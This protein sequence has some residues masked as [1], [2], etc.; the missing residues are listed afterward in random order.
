MRKLNLFILG[1]FF[2]SVCFSFSTSPQTG[3][4]VNLSNSKLIRAGSSTIEN[5]MGDSK[6]EIIVGDSGGM[7]YAVNSTGSE[8]WRYNTGT[9]SIES[10]PAVADL[11]GNGTKEIIVSSGSTFTA[12]AVGSLTVLNNNGTF[13]CNYTPQPFSPQGALGVFSSPAVANLDSDP[14]LEIVI[15]DWGANILVLNHDCSILW[16]SQ[17]APAVTGVQL[18]PGFNEQVAPHK[19]YVND[20]IWSSPAIADMNKDG[21]LDIIIGVDSHIDDNNI[22]ID[23]GRILV[24]NG[25]N[26]TVQ[27]AID[28]DEVIWSSPAIADINNDGNL[29]IIV[30]TGYCW[31]NP[32]CVPANISH[33]VDNKIY[34]YNLNGTPIAGWPFDLGDFATVTSSPAIADI[35]G[36]GS[37][38][39]IVHAFLIG[40]GPPEVG[41]VIVLNSNGTPKWQRR[42]NVP[43]F[44]DPNGCTFIEYAAKNASPIV[45]D[46]TGDGELDVILP[47]NFDIV[48]WDKNG[49]QLLPLPPPGVRM[50][51]SF[52]ISSTPNIAD[53]DQDGDYELIATGSN[54]FT[55]PALPASIYVWD[56]DAA[57]S[58]FLPWRSFRNG[59]KNN[60]LF[61]ADEIFE[62]GFE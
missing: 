44:C 15:G 59:P 18:P 21:Q 6:P 22:T 40:S 43:N 46:M 23:G 33:A 27:T 49:T 57:T 13:K 36:D 26:G 51:T 52:T 12:A 45:V 50:L 20:T 10:K 61:L 58:T 14:E 41:K 30:G 5:I 25:H 8:L 1:T 54:A 32:P 7:V 37:L 24:I 60:G 17:Q 2:S 4:P 39:V 42:P 19:V 11:D 28:I 47:S 34:A 48:I 16:R 29:D 9:A 35:D 3:F 38:E 62:N 56:I 31:Q 55:N 53:L